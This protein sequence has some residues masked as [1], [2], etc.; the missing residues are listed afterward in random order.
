MFAL[1][2][3]KM[4]PS[5]VFWPLAGPPGA[6]PAGP[7]RPGGALLARFARLTLVGKSAGFT[8]RRLA[9]NYG[10]E[11]KPT[12]SPR[13]CGIGTDIRV[14]QQWSKL[15]RVRRRHEKRNIAK[16][17]S[18]GYVPKYTGGIFSVNTGT[19]HF[20]KFGMASI[21]VPG[22]SVSSVFF[23]YRYPTLR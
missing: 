11:M 3:R 4:K 13:Y 8:S 19:R 17:C 7:P 23:Q 20:G 1:F 10:R 12:H 18:V 2:L 9:T 21:P 15:T 22:T 5:S 14:Y 16:V 6:P